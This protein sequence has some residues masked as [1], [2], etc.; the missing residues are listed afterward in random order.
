[1]TEPR[2]IL[3][4]DDELFVRELLLEFLGQ[5]GFSVF[6]ADRG[7]RAIELTKDRHYDMCLLDLKMPGMTGLDVLQEFEKIENAPL[8]MLMTGY[9]TVESAVACLRSGVFD[10][11]IKP[12]K[13]PELLSTVQKGLKEIERRRREEDV[14]RRLAY[15]EAEVSTYKS[16]RQVIEEPVE[17][18]TPTVEE[19]PRPVARTAQ[20]NN[21]LG[22][23]EKL[24]EL[25]SK[26]VVE[27]KEYRAKKDEL[28]SRL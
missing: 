7:S 27:E 19:A 4:V 8:T 26:G 16:V 23:L 11:V 9:P 2:S 22:L 14:S 25:R 3:V 21:I 12:F 15:L 20:Q 5:N 17:I 28:L 6:L 10:Y 1:M 13:L 18:E 24:G